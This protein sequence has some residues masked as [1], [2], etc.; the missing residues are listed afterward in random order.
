MHGGQKKE[1]RTT[2]CYVTCGALVQFCSDMSTVGGLVLLTLLTLTHLLQ[3]FD[4]WRLN[5]I[6]LV[7]KVRKRVLANYILYNLRTW[8]HHIL[9]LFDSV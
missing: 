7:Q 6:F 1:Q 2:I 5:L 8:I 9:A 4:L 3:K